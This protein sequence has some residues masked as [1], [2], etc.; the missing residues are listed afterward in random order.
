M[1]VFNGERYLHQALDSILRQTYADLELVVVD[2]GSSDGTAAILASYDDSRLRVLR[3]PRN[4]GLAASLNRG[5]AAAT[6]EFIARQ[7]ADDISEPQRIASQVAYLD[8]HPDVALVGSAHI[9]IDA[10]GVVIGEVDAHCDHVAILWAMLFFCPFAHT[11]V[12]WRREPVLHAVG[13]YDE[14]Y[15]YS[16]DFEYWT[17]I[18]ARFRVANLPGHFVRLRSHGQSMTATYGRHT[19]EGPRLR[20]AA[21]AELLG[22]RGVAP[23]SPEAVHELL[24]AL[25][26]GPPAPHD[27]PRLIAGVS[28]LFELQH[29]FADRWRLT[30]AENVAHLRDLRVHVSETLLAFARVQASTDVDPGAVRRL[31]GAAIRVLPRRMLR[32]GRAI[33]A[34]AL[35]GS[36]YGAAWM[37]RWRIS[38]SRWS[39]REG[40]SE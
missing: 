4:I 3:N 21:V 14:S 24:S 26:F 17:R 27:T 11:A 32:P 30:P 23:G 19:G 36:V 35:V 9:E 28:T 33:A 6:G 2:D 8:T 16:M 13:T 39:R 20:V 38:G 12:M 10:D 7:D 40:G 22:L 31:V 18:A 1:S 5:I 37:R 15:R 34:V 29:A 25:V